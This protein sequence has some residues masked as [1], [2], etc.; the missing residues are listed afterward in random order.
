MKIRENCSVLLQFDYKIV[1]NGEF[2]FFSKFL[3]KNDIF[4]NLF[5]QHAEFIVKTAEGLKDLVNNF[6]DVNSRD[7]YISNINKSEHAAD[8]VTQEVNRLIHKTFITPIDREQIH[9]LINMMDDTADAIQDTAEVLILYNVTQI[10]PDIIGLTDLSLK[11]CERVRYAVSLLANVGKDN[12][13][14]AI[15]KTCEEIDILESDADRIMRSAM[16][17]LFH[18][19]QDA[20]ELIKLK[21]IYELLETIT[22]K[23]EDVANIIEGIVLENS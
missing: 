11:A 23:C 17:D 19:D 18:N 2:M 15:L 16:S 22:D 7:L 13:A 20:K 21:A 5:D 12:T 4:F 8:R 6:Q 1:T 14:I 3:P 10:N 9:A